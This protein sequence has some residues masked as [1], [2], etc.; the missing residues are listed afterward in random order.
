MDSLLALAPEEVTSSFL[1]LGGA[2]VA[3]GAASG[4]VAWFLG[5]PVRVVLSIFDA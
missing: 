1:S 2:M 3:A 4:F 5:T